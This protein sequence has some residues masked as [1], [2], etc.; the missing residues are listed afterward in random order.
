[1]KRLVSALAMGSPLAGLVRSRP[2]IDLTASS[3]RVLLADG[4]SGTAPPVSHHEI[5]DY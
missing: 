4:L 3:M 1:M 2:A 5:I